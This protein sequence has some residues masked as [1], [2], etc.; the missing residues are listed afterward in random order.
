MLWEEML[1][2][3]GYDA[4]PVVCMGMDRRGNICLLIPS[5]MDDGRNVAEEMIIISAMEIASRKDT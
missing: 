3:H 4:V 2:H 1:L 5:D